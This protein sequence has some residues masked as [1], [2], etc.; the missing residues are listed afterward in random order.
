MQIVILCGG[1]GTRLSEYTNKIPKPLVEIGGK[2]ILWHIMKF[3]AHQG[4]NDFILC[5][6]YKGEQIREYF[7]DM[8][9]FKITFVDTGLKSNKAERIK[10][11]EK[12]I[13]DNEF[14]V[15]YGDDLSDINLKNL[16]ECHKD[17]NTLV[18]LTA[19]KPYSQFGILQLAENNTVTGFKEKPRLDHWINGGFF[20]FNKKIFQYLKEGK[21]LEKEVFEQ[22]A[23]ENQISAFKHEGFWKCMNTFK[24][25]LELNELW[26][27]NQ[28]K[29]KIW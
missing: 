3:Y 8:S 16:L 14:F 23:K 12:Y 18:T 7:K 28:A 10:K 25:T 24:D 22:L 13:T 4:F 11:V 27:N 21:D 15:A 9:E 2:P 26:E 17:K 29:W 20:V 1:E 5:L 6:G 19:I